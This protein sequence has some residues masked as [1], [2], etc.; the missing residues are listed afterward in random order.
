VGACVFGQ[1]TEGVEG[2]E[3]QDQFVAVEGFKAGVGKAWAHGGSLCLLLSHG[4]GSGANELSGRLEQSTL[5]W[6]GDWW[7]YGEHRYGDRKTL[8]ESEEW[9]GPAYDTCVGAV[10]VCD[11]FEKLRRRSNLPV[12]FHREVAA[13]PPEEAD[14]VLDECEDVQESILTKS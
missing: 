9:N 12:S 1:L 11:R 10:W 5:W 7:A 3:Q 13:L 2:Q 8:V 6:I 4:A 14:R